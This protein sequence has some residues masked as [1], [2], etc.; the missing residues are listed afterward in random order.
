M[1]EEIVELKGLEDGNFVITRT[2]TNKMDSSGLNSEL[3]KI[4]Y[5]KERYIQDLKHIKKKYDELIILEDEI[6]VAMSKKNESINII[7]EV[8]G[9]VGV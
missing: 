1:K 3:A 2:I 7:D 6:K 4:A 9:I 5:E 8:E